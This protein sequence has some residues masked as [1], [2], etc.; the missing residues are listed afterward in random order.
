MKNLPAL[1]L[2]L[3][4]IL[5]SGA[6]AKADDLAFSI[7]PLTQSVTVGDATP[8]LFYATVT[9]TDALGSASL[10]LDGD[11]IDLVSEPSPLPADDLEDDT[12]FW[13]NF[14]GTIDPQ[15]SITDQLLLAVTV[16]DPATAPGLY[17]Q[18]FQ[19][20]DE[21][22]NELGTADFSFTVTAASSTPTSV[23]PEPSS[24]FLL[25][26]G[27]LGFAALAGRKSAQGKIEL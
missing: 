4:G 14:N 21:N 26:T 12:G 2:A 19:I 23:T 3:M 27:L 8:I 1:S 6:S 5:L 17:E 18:T 22:N 10:N 24:F 25:G 7:T 20:L 16:S 13:L 9:D 11:A 15:T